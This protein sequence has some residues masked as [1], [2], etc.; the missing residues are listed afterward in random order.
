VQDDQSA[1]LRELFEQ[2]I[3]GDLGDQSEFTDYRRYLDF[4][5]II[6]DSSGAP[7]S[8]SKV[9]REKSGGETQT[10]FYIV[11]LAAFNQLYDSQ[12]AMRLVVF[13]EAFNKMDEARIQTSLRLIKQLNLQLVAAVPDE[14][15]Q[16]MAR[17]VQTTLIVTRQDH[18][19]F[20][21]RLGLEDEE[22]EMDELGSVPR[23]IA[24][25]PN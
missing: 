18:R 20:V 22:E 4:D 19:C 5:I 25:L 6:T 1:V 17:E 11:I 15:M 13:D 23:Q 10:P 14:K 16:H 12:R 21:D 3:R 9:L 24:P 2:L 7:T 8:F